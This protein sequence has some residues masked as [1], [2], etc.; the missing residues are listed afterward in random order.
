[1]DFSKAI[2]LPR[3]TILHPTYPGAPDTLEYWKV[4]DGANG[5]DRELPAGGHVK[6]ATVD[7]LIKSGQFWIRGLPD[8]MDAAT[9]RVV[10]TVVANEQDQW[11]DWTEVD[12]DGDVTREWPVRISIG[13]G[14]IHEVG[15][16]RVSTAAE[17]FVEVAKALRAVAD[18]LEPPAQPAVP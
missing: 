1:M 10:E 2:A 7:D 8:E 13:D 5:W 4:R 15:T 16:I 14:S 18:D 3:G 11:S 12:A 9:R 6:D 17:A